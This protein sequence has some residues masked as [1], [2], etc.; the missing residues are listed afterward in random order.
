[1]LLVGSVGVSVARVQLRYH[2]DEGHVHEDASR[3]HEDPGSQV[4]KVTQ[5]HTDHHPDEGENRA[6]KNWRLKVFK[7]PFFLQR[8]EQPRTL[9]TF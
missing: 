3:P 2:V 5:Q 6:L 1:M 4:L 7:I 9:N 8:R